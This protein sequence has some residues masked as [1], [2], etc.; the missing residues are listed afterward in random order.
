MEGG[1]GGGERER[2]EE[3]KALKYLSDGRQIWVLM[4]Y[5]ATQ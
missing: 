5:L 3:K 2:E 1:R 4:L